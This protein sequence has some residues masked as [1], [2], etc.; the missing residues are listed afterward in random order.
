MSSPQGNQESSSS[1]FISSP[2]IHSNSWTLPNQQSTWF[3]N[4]SS[5]T[6]PNFYEA[7]QTQNQNGFSYS[8]QTQNQNGPWSLTPN[9]NLNPTPNNQV[10]RYSQETI[11]KVMSQYQSEDEEDLPLGHQG[12]GV[13]PPSSLETSYRIDGSQNTSYRIDGSQNTSHGIDGSQNTSHGI[14]GSQNTLVNVKKGLRRRRQKGAHSVPVD[15]LSHTGQTRGEI[16]AEKLERIVTTNKNTTE[17]LLQNQVASLLQSQASLIA[18]Q[19]SQTKR[20]DDQSKQIR[21]LATQVKRLTQ[22]ISKGFDSDDERKRKRPKLSEPPKAQP[23]V[24]SIHEQLRLAKQHNMIPFIST[25]FLTGIQLR[26]VRFFKD[27]NVGIT[28][29]S[30]NYNAIVHVFKTAIMM[31]RP[32]QFT[33]R[34]TEKKKKF[35]KE[36]DTMD[37]WRHRIK[38]FFG[39][40]EQDKRYEKEIS[41]SYQ[42][43]I[44]LVDPVLKLDEY[45][46]YHQSSKEILSD[47]KLDKDGKTNWSNINRLTKDKVTFLIYYKTSLT[48]SLGKIY[49]WISIRRK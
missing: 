48:L 24:L 38:L 10:V 7:N 27:S 45:K 2:D 43:L 46:Q 40:D 23:R 28:Y 6:I 37:D 19:A 36:G 35:V 47:E 18:T 21:D 33:L 42:R 4:G 34:S 8:S 1:I 22:V 31:Q 32:I 29:V 20:M 14:D 5:Y 30:L 17:T 44:D 39:V 25:M 15:E 11:D 13:P 49:H 41:I 9:L 3:S 12:L 26:L 16:L